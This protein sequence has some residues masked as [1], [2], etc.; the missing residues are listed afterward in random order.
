MLI[1]IMPY[2]VSQISAVVY[3]KICHGGDFCKIFEGLL[4]LKNKPSVVFSFSI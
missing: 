1:K 2:I 3:N 4:H